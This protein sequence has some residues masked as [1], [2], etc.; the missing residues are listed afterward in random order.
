[1]NERA[2]FLAA[3][4][5]LE[6]AVISGQ[7]L[8]EWV[9]PERTSEGHWTMG[10]PRY[11]DVLFDA[12]VATSELLDSTGLGPFRSEEPLESPG[13]VDAASLWHVACFLQTILRRERFIDGLIGHHLEAGSLLAAALRLR[14]AMVGPDQPN[15]A[16]AEA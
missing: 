7:R 5:L 10:W 2:S 11:D 14:E 6:D 16:G 3:V 13:A 8:V 15:P 12:L 4:Q 9:P 1:M